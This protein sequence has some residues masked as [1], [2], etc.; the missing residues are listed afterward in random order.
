MQFTNRT[1]ISLYPVNQIAET[2]LIFVGCD[3]NSNLF[4]LCNTRLVEFGLRILYVYSWREYWLNGI[5]TG[6]YD[7]IVLFELNR[8]TSTVLSNSV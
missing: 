1:G 4:W 5:S 2:F 7:N 6:K 3:D 8:C